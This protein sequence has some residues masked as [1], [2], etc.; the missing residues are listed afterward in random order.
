MHNGKKNGGQSAPLG[1]RARSSK[2]HSDSE[3][4][5]LNGY[6]LADVTKLYD[7]GAWL[8]P[9]KAGKKYPI[10]KRWGVE[11]LPLDTVCDHLRGGAAL[12]VIPHSL[13]VAVV[14]VDRGGNEAVETVTKALGK[15]LAKYE[16]S[17]GK[18][19]L[20]YH[21]PADPNY[22][23]T[24]EYGDLLVGDPG[25]RK[26][27][28]L[29]PDWCRTWYDASTAD[30]VEVPDFAA[31]PGTREG[32]HKTAQ[33]NAASGGWQEGARNDTLYKV[34]CAIA[35][36]P[37]DTRTPLYKAVENQALISGLEKFEIESTISSAMKATDKP[38]RP[39]PVDITQ[40][41]DD[42]EEPPTVLRQ[43]ESSSGSVLAE[44]EICLL[45]AAGG[46]GKSYLTLQWANAATL[47]SPTP[48]ETAMVETCGL[49]V[50]RGPVVFAAYEDSIP[51]CKVR[52]KLVRGDRER[53][54]PIL[55]LP[56]PTPLWRGAVREGPGKGEDWE[57]L[58]NAVGEANASLVVIDPATAAFAGASNDLSEVREFMASLAAE[59]AAHKCGVLLVTHSTKAARNAADGGSSMG[60]GAVAGSAAWH[61]S[62]RSVLM[63]R[64][65]DNGNRLLECLKANYGL[66]GWGAELKPIGGEG[67]DQ[68]FGGFELKQMLKEKD[69]RRVLKEN[70]ENG[71]SGGR[72]DVDT[73]GTD[74]GGNEDN[75][76]IDYSPH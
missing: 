38:A 11:R 9:R 26:L 18:T 40:D 10:V 46:V 42:V 52:L 33:S 70:K 65:L 14:D 16:S 64:I 5:I 19:H 58:W 27:C 2:L 57:R 67:T 3:G 73:L 68:P 41:L 71:E 62:A 34:T 12:S 59:A 44:G 55:A 30:S 28:R 22:S 74:L 15:P 47:P 8:V 45:S 25:S 1:S 23:T 75:L 7:K 63:F 4:V 69:V 49:Q 76:N 48:D 39:D 13:G 21:A 51:R 20:L 56:S 61:D 17:P 72:D 35:Q 32:Q 29:E 54:H 31:L 6:K 43:A 66:T 60:A 37:E 50:R 24:W 36:L 53:H